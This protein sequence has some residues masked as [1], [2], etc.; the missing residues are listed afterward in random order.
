MIRIFYCFDFDNDTGQ[1]LLPGLSPVKEKVK[2][3]KHSRALLLL[4]LVSKTSLNLV[5]V[6]DFQYTAMIRICYFTMTQT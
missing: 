1:A 5:L 3:V 6:L 2:V 4:S